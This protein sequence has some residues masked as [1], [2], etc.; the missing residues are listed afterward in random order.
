MF[1]SVHVAMTGDTRG[2]LNGAF[3]AAMRPVR[4][5]SSTPR[6]AKWWTNRRCWRPC[7][8]AGSGAGLDVFAGEPAG[9]TAEFARVTSRKNQEVYGPHHIGASTE[10]A[11]EAIAAES[12]RIVREFM[13]TGKVPNV[14]NLARKTPAT[15]ALIVRHRDRPGVLASVLD[16][17]RQANIN[18]QEM[19]NTIFDGAEAGGGAHSPGAGAFARNSGGDGR[20]GRTSWS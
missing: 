18:V 12:V 10:Q 11:Q 19:E 13:T 20:F 17:I 9:G 16:S 14:V 15:C 6:A 8:R 7:A 2:F 1:V 5:S 4:V 3:F